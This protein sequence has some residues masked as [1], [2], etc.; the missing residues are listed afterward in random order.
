M[1]MAEC[2]MHGKQESH[3]LFL[4]SPK[5]IRGLL[6]LRAVFY[7]QIIC[8]NGLC[9]RLLRFPLPAQQTVEI[10]VIAHVVAIERLSIDT[11]RA[12]SRV[13]HTRR[14]P[15]RCTRKR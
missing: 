5:M 13:F 9:R 7:Q 8:C 4:H 2:R 6:R 1:K 14:W 11:L 3:R 12:G 10:H 15:G